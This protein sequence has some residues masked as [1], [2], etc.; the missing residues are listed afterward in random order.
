MLPFACT[1]PG[2]RKGGSIVSLTALIRM[3]T[4]A[5]TRGMRA[6]ADCDARPYAHTVISLESGMSRTCWR[7]TSLFS[8]LFFFTQICLIRN[9]GPN[10]SAA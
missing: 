5:P 3:G 4:R 9:L 10:A 8:P 1:H 2:R 6:H 7:V